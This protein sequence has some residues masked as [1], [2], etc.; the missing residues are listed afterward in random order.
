MKS[1]LIGM[2]TLMLALPALAERKH[3]VGEHDVH[4]IAFN[5]SFLQP[6][7]AAAAGLVRS[8]TQGVVNVSVLKAGKP[9]AAQVSGS[10]KNL[11][12]QDYPLTFKQLKEGEEAI[13]YLAQFPFESREVLRFNL[14]V[15][16]SGAAPIDFDFTQEFFPDE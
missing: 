2:L 7:I 15:R 6:D 12:G 9:V 10:V 16:P 14:N 5:S 13:Y 3:S 11:L 4:Y 1:I 8:K